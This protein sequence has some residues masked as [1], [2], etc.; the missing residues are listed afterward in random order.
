MKIGDLIKHRPLHRQIIEGERKLMIGIVIE[1]PT[2]THAKE[3][4]KV[5]VLTDDGVESWVMQF[6]EVIESG[7][8]STLTPGAV[9]NNKK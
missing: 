7:A 4:Q 9:H 8:S 5:K 1:F 6:C 2:P 3:F